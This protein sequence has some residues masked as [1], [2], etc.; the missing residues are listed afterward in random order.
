[1]PVSTARFL[2]RFDDICPGMN[3]NVWGEIEAILR[4]H[5]VKPILAVVP[6]NQDPHLTVG[7]EVQDFW[8]RVR[9]WQS[10]GW[11]IG[12]HGYQHV[13]SS[14]ASGLM[15]LNAR[16][17]FAGLS[18]DAQAGKLARA[19]DIFSREGVRADCWVAPGHSFDA[20][21]VALLRERGL[22]VISDGFYLRPVRWQGCLWVPQQLWRFRPM[23]SGVWTV[24]YHHNAF[25]AAQISLLA[26]NVT[27]YADALTSLHA[28]AAQPARPIG[29][30][31]RLTQRAWLA[32]L[33]AKRVLAKRLH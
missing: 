23:P 29:V 12:L 26:A 16:S 31:D 8:D 4:A 27:T 1:M 14:G 21:T 7:P 11:A 33:R 24:C 15:G 25:G 32:A 13:Y 18:R 6:D 28:V 3:W 20:V 17:E 5:D 9:K 19:F 30:A 22:C 10:W 2:V